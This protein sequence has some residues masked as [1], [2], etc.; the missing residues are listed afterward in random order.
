MITHSECTGTEPEKFEI[1]YGA[2]GVSLWR[3]L[4]W[5]SVK[6]QSQCDKA[7]EEFGV[8]FF[9]GFRRHLS[10]F[11]RGDSKYIGKTYNKKL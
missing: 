11:I 5:E 7:Y 10:S 1:M 3:L 2:I 9:A 6:M 4:A 8:H